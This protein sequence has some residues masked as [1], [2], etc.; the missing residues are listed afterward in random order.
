LFLVRNA[1]EHR[2]HQMRSLRLTEGIGYQEIDGEPGTVKAETCDKCY[3]WVKILQQHKDPAIE[4]IADDVA[5]LGL[6]LL[7]REGPYRRGGFNP[8]LTGY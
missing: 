7:M 2:S 5:S 8:F 6:D 4:P 1:L 3:G